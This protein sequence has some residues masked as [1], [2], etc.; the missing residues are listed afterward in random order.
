MVVTARCT[1]TA[2]ERLGSWSACPIALRFI[3]LAQASPWVQQTE[4]DVG[5]GDRGQEGFLGF[6][7]A[8][9]SDNA[10]L[11]YRNDDT[12]NLD[13][14]RIRASRDGSPS[15]GL[16]SGAVGLANLDEN[17]SFSYFQ[18]AGRRTSWN[19][20]SPCSLPTEDSPRFCSTPRKRVFRGVV[21]TPAT[22][23]HGDS[24]NPTA[25]LG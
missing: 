21:E 13:D 9:V 24:R 11:P 5:I 12:D 1:T 20:R 17:A 3:G 15:C 25:R 19:E 4:M 22:R 18:R 8:R 6:F 23:H 16:D 10:D 7:T 14:V 2:S